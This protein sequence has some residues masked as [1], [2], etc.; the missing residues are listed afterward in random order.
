MN[1]QFIKEN[2]INILLTILYAM[3]TLLIVT[4]H[5]IWADEAQVWQLCKYL[6]LPELFK[7]L[8]NEGHPSF[9]YLSVNV[10]YKA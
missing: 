3:F 8:V 9:F 7:H 6:S 5:E 4:H 2:K 1:F 10:L